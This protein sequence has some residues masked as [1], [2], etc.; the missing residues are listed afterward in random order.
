M[1]AAPPSLATIAAHRARAA[2]DEAIRAA[3]V[4]TAALKDHRT[5]S[6]LD[7][8]SRSV[9]AASLSITC[10]SRAITVGEDTVEDT[11]ALTI[12][13]SVAEL[14]MIVADDARAEVIQ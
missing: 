4:A 11:V 6:A 9:R 3:A 8:A 1:T 5:T 2:S 12:A 10:Y 7:A 13:Q 14:A